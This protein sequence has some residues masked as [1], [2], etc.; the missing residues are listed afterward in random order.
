MSAFRAAVSLF[1][2]SHGGSTGLN[3]VLHGCERIKTSGVLIFG[4]FNLQVTTPVSPTDSVRPDLLPDEEPFIL[5][6][7]PAKQSPVTPATPRQVRTEN[8]EMSNTP[9]SI[10]FRSI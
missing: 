3:L 1:R 9:E 2:F 5:T 4:F 10:Q 8:V 7:S 6:H